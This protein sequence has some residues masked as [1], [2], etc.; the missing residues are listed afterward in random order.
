[1]DMVA[2]QPVK[3]RK[4]RQR[5]KYLDIQVPEAKDERR[6]ALQKLYERERCLQKLCKILWQSTFGGSPLLGARVC[7]LVFSLKQ[8]GTKKRKEAKKKASPPKTCDAQVQCDLDY[9]ERVCQTRSEQLERENFR[10]RPL[11]ACHDE[12]FERVSQCFF[13][14]GKCSGT[15]G[16]Q[17]PEVSKSKCRA[18]GW[19]KRMQSST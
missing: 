17:Q 6:A 10:L 13:L 12:S 4:Q 5:V 9:K 3:K 8:Q 7:V 19:M 14:L 15:C 1:M 16:L 11:V 18:N 2:E